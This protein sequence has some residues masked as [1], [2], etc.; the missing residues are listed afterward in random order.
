MYSCISKTE[1]ATRMGVSISTLRRYLRAIENRLPHY[2]RAQKMLT[3][4]Q[5]QVFSEHYCV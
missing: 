4:D 3:P 2:D 1:L 5:Y